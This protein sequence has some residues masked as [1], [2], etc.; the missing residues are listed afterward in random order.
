MEIKRDKRNDYVN[1]LKIIILVHLRHSSV[2]HRHHFS[3]RP[4]Y[5]VALLTRMVATVLTLM[6]RPEWT[7][8]P[9]E[10]GQPDRS[11]CT[12]YLWLNIR[13]ACDRNSSI[14][15]SVGRKKDLEQ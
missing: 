3:P 4:K 8:I 1:A 12:P 13:T 14:A 9:F 2:V 11:S 6:E 7:G 10:S 15:S 5:A